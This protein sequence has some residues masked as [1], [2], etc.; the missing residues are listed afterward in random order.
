MLLPTY[1]HA[2]RREFIGAGILGTLGLA[3]SPM[4]QTLLAREESKKRAKSCILVWLN[5][6][7]SHIDTFDPKPGVDTG[8]P[9]KAID[10]KVPGMKLCEHLPKLADQ[11]KHL[12]VVRS[13]TSKEA[14][15]DRA[16]FFLHTGNLRDETVDYPGLGAVVANEWRDKEGD[17]PS[18]VSLNGTAPGGG[19]LGLNFDPYVVGNLDAPLDNIN[20]PDGV[21]EDRLAR[22]LKAL[23]ALNKRYA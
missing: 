3:L 11:A 5:G 2:N 21:D 10:T 6:G 4:M 13:L 23:D 12:A 22:R 14:D 15:H 8:G 17:L 16:Y 9:F 20:L 7:P 18:F 1:R 19:F